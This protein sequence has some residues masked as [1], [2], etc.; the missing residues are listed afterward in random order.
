MHYGLSAAMLPLTLLARA[1]LASAEPPTS[2]AADASDDLT[3]VLT[4]AGTHVLDHSQRC[5]VA[6]RYLLRG[7]DG[8]FELSKQRELEDHHP[9]ER[10][11]LRSLSLTHREGHT[12]IEQQFRW[13][14][15]CPVEAEDEVASEPQ[16]D[17]AQ[18]EEPGPDWYVARRVHPTWAGPR[19]VS[20]L[21]EESGFWGGAHGW[22]DYQAHTI[23]LE[24]C[25]PVG[26]RDLFRAGTWRTV[27]KPLI[28]AILAAWD[29][30]DTPGDPAFDRDVL[31]MTLTS[32]LENHTFLLTHGPKGPVSHL[33]YRANDIHCYASGGVWLCVPVADLDVDIRRHLRPELA[34]VRLALPAG[35]TFVFPKLETC[36]QGVLADPEDRVGE[37]LHTQKWITGTYRVTG[38]DRQTVRLWLNT[39]FRRPSRPPHDNLVPRW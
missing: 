10:L 36:L 23:D 27:R 13:S 7:A 3:V 38:T 33:V 35:G 34:S 30:A 16:Q 15:D 14:S 20:Y 29:K 11:T 5:F 1:E 8:F 12:E 26:L 39:V 22:Y 24:T 28:A 32:N 17:N 4:C 31:E 21:I 2:R 37:Q 25:R 18:N 6:D 9:F 19:F